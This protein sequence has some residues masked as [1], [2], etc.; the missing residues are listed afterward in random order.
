MEKLT[1]LQQDQLLE[2]LDGNLN[3]IEKKKFEEA[4]L[5]NSLLRS[6][7]EE[8]QSI[9]TLLQFSKQDHPAKNFT[10]LVMA[11]LTNY[12]AAYSSTSVRNGI[13]LLLG[14]LLA[15]GI[16]TVLL[17]EGIF[18][19]TIATLDV[20]NASFFERIGQ[21]AIPAIAINGKIVVNIIILLNLG[22]A[23]LVLDRAILR[24][25]FRKRSEQMF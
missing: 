19:N 18:D 13:F 14:V 6:R 12:P 16:G 9:H 15:V 23:W 22:L 20:G 17:T 7:L 8:V 1:Q 24:P 10:D 21:R 4:I 3:E 5:K 11:N 25:L 2:Y